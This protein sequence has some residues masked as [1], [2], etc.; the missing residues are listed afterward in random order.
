[1]NED[2][3][4]DQW[5][6]PCKCIG[7]LKY[8][9]QN[10]IQQ[11]IDTTLKNNQ[12]NKMQCTQCKTEFIILFPNSSKFVYCLVSSPFD[13]PTSHL[14]ADIYQQNIFLTNPILT[15]AFSL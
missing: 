7:S 6:A 3:N 2:E 11:W 13:W 10:C 1:M 15:I 5:V 4:N 9:H 14:V 8:V 12:T